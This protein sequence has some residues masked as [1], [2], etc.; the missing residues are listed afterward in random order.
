[1]KT[2]FLTISMIAVLAAWP[3]SPVLAQDCQVTGGG[4][5]EQEIYSSEATGSC[6]NRARFSG[7]LVAPFDGVRCDTSNPVGE[8]VVDLADGTTFE[9]LEIWNFTFRLDGYDIATARGLGLYEGDLV[10]FAIEF[11]GVAGRSGTDLDYFVA[12]GEYVEGPL[13]GTLAFNARGVVVGG[14]VTMV[15]R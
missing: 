11:E 13:M 4:V 14:S 7:N 6:R 12:L 1:M 9:T 8:W 2:Q 5:F 3:A 15:A 10:E